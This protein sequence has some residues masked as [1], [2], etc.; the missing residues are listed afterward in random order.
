MVYSKIWSINSPFPS[1]L[2]PL[3]QSEAKCKAIDMKMIFYFHVNLTHFHKKGFALRLV[4]KVMRVFGTRK[5]PLATLASD[6]RR[7]EGA[8]L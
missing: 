6:I 1:F 3:F 2:K 7:I 8:F 4:L 5:W